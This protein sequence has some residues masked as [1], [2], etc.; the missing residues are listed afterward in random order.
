MCGPRRSGMSALGGLIRVGE[1]RTGIA[2][3]LAITV[4]VT[5]LARPGW[6]WP[7]SAAFGLRPEN[8]SAA[9]C[10]HLGSRVVVPVEAG[11]SGPVGR[12]LQEYGAFVVDAHTNAEYQVGIF[13]EQG[14]A[15]ELPADVDAEL[16]KWLPWLRVVENAGP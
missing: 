13:V 11:V 2:H 14:V 5:M 3:A 9:G 12:A 4:P 8:L 7:A 10:L 16:S 6:V 1:A 15:D